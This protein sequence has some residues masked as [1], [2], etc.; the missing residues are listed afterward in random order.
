MKI[1]TIANFVISCLK[2]KKRD[3]AMH[4]QI[5]TYTTVTI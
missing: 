1:E 2:N 4:I 3:R 5:Q